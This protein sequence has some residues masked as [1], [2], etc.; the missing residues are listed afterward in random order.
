MILITELKFLG[1]WPSLKQSTWSKLA[2]YPILNFLL[3][4][5]E[6]LSD[7]LTIA[8]AKVFPT[9][10]PTPTSIYPACPSKNDLK[11]LTR[12]TIASHMIPSPVLRASG[13]LR[14]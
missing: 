11:N 2:S 3:Q 4:S 8:S 14:R 1:N 13:P 12:E 7:F 6:Y 10:D 9:S 5:T